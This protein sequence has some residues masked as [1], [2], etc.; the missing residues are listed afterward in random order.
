M[1]ASQEGKPQWGDKGPQNA[2]YYN[3]L[4]SG[5]PFFE[6]GEDGFLSDYG[7]FFLVCI[8][9]KVAYFHV[10][11]SHSIVRALY[12]V[13]HKNVNHLLVPFNLEPMYVAHIVLNGGGN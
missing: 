5:V 4:P 6:G 1:A 7:R 13:F 2:G 9:F 3:S 12:V 10:F 11:I 8:L